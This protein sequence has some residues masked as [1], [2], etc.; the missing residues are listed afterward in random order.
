VAKFY[1]KDGKVHDFGNVADGDEPVYRFIYKNVG[2][3]PLFIT[4]ITLSCE[5]FSVDWPR[6]PIQPGG[7]GWISVKFPFTGRLGSFGKLLWVV[8]NA[9][10]ASDRE[11]LMIS[12][13]VVAGPVTAKQAAFDF[14]GGQTHDFGKIPEGPDVSYQF[15]FRNKGMKAL[16]I[17]DVVSDCKC[18]T[19]NFQ[20]EPVQP[21]RA[22]WI[23]VT[24]HTKGRS[25]SFE[26]ALR[27][28]GNAVKKGEILKV[29]IKGTVGAG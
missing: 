20:K 1:F 19:A 3:S 4:D 16:S 8:S 13:N 10:M 12:G 17:R 15:L 25:G 29:N 23:R 27:I 6:Y 24:Y 11:E 22:G 18:M 21:G 2:K 14:L 7:E 9:M 28:R 26:K 5:C